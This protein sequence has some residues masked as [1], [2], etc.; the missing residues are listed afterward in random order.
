[1]DQNQSPGRLYVCPMHPKVRQATPGRCP[2]C[3]MDLLPEGTKFGM[4]RHM[5]SSPA[6]LVV[7]GAVMVVVMIAAMVMIR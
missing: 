5:M 6:H 7:M 3:G 2:T 4:L 1:M